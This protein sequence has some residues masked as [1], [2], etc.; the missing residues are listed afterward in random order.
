MASKINEMGSE[1]VEGYACK[2]KNFN[3][4][5]PIMHYKSILFVCDDQRCRKAHKE[6]KSIYLR[7]L[8]KDMNLN[9]GENRVKITRTSCNGACRFRGVVQLYTTSSNLLNNALW[10][11][12][13][14]N[15]DDNQWRE[16][17]KQL[18]QDKPLTN[19]LDKSHFIPMKVYE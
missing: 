5:R 17:F 18:S 6:D 12:E 3:P 1:V 13:T 2:P 7:E 11:K 9:R 15:F 14:H 19:I 10:L 4:N 16:I 8:I